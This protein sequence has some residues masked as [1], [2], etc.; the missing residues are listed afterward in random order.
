M[1]LG[2]LKRTLHREFMR[3]PA[4]SATLLALIPVAGYFIAPLLWKQLPFAK[5]GKP[6]QPSFVAAAGAPIA[7]EPIAAV[8]GPLSLPR[9]Q[10]VA[11]WI[12][13]D[14][15]M[16]PSTT[17]SLRDPFRPTSTS[18]DDQPGVEAESTAPAPSAASMRPEDCGLQ[19]TATIVGT[20]KRLA[21]I[22]GRLYSENA[23]VGID[24][25]P[26]FSAEPPRADN[27]FVL[28][29]VAKS[30][31]VLERHGEQFQLRIAGGAEK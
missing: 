9:W 25:H 14:K 4:K 12:I 31:V 22:N 29:T 20:T 11:E 30:H 16:R 6:S 24:N 7:G 27:A 17:V 3:N 15:R 28:K 23:L 1:S 26:G 5:G 13:Q 19:L 2:K 21:T 10:D 8:T 18:K